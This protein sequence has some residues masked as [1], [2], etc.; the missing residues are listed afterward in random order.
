M[1]DVTPDPT[2]FHIRQYIKTHT[3]L[4]IVNV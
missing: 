4:F 1:K 2:K 3:G